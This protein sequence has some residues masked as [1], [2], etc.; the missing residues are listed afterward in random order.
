MTEE[1][2]GAPLATSEAVTFEPETCR[3]KGNMGTW[4]FWLRKVGTVSVPR[5]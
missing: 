5:S 3:I 4:A 1:R 2:G